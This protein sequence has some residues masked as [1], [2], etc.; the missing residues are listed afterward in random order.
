MLASINFYFILFFHRLVDN[1]RALLASPVSTAQ[2]GGL[3]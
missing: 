3:H 2:I 1:P